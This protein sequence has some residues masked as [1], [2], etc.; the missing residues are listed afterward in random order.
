MGYG[1]TKEAGEQRVKPAVKPQLF[2][3]HLPS[4]YAIALGLHSHLRI[5]EKTSVRTNWNK[6]PGRK[7]G[8]QGDTPSM[9]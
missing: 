1:N 9:K 4:L 2:M 8:P 3:G 7:Q 6:D 5:G